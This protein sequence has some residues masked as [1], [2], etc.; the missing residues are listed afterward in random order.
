MEAEGQCLDDWACWL[1]IVI[2]RTS[3]SK[4]ESDSG[5]VGTVGGDLV[6]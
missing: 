1:D 6:L 2:I 3:V 5:R 4:S